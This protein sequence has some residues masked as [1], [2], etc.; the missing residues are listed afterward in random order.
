MEVSMRKHKPFNSWADAEIAG[1]ID[2]AADGQRDKRLPMWERPENTR[3]SA[4]ASY[5]TDYWRA[6]DVAY[7]IAFFNGRS[8]H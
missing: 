7:D 8:D 2:G 1:V 6:Y 3:Y 5:G 4:D